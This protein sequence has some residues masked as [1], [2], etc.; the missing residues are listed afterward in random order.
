MLTEPQ[1][2]CV[3]VTAPI[4]FVGALWAL[5]DLVGHVA[6]LTPA[7]QPGDTLRAIAGHAVRVAVLVPAL[8]TGALALAFGR[9]VRP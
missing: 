2:A 3:V 6:T 5:G 4:V 9:R 7:P 8:I 1:L